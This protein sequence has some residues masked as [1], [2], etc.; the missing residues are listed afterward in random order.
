MRLSLV[1]S[2]TSVTLA[3]VVLLGTFESASADTIIPLDQTRYVSTFLIVPQCSRAGSDEDEA[4]GFEPFDSIIETLI[5][6]D[7]G[8]GF[9]SGSQQS[10]IGPNSMTA[11]GSGTSEASGP[12]LNIVH[13]GGGLVL[14]RDIRVGVRR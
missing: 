2:K 1:K 13:A 7:L 8:L 3:S 4:D 12:A 5:D 14:Q 11:F 10:Q 9:S 6:C